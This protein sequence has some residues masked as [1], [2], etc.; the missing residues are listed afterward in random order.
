MPN[1][2][3]NFNLPNSVAQHYHVDWPYTKEFMITNVAVVDTDVENGAIDVVPGTHKKFYKFWR[4]ALER[5]YRFSK[6]LPLQQGDV[7]IRT[8]NLWHRG[9]PNRTNTPRP[10]VAL[11]WEE[12]GSQ[13]DDPFR[14]ENGKIRF[15]ENWYRSNFLGRMR[16]RTFM[17]APITYDAYR[18]VRSLVGTKGYDH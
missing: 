16:E 12:G 17:A 18:F 6:Q 9:M 8:S 10:M 11:T 5:P 15:R 13:L 1:I 2:G 14:M 4:F 7:L 3:C